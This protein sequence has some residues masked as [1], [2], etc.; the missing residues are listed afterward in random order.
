[1]KNKISIAAAVILTALSLRAAQAAED[2]E[3]WEVTSQMDMP[4][5]PSG[6]KMP[7]GMMGAMGGR[8]SQVCRGADP[9]EAVSKDK[10]MHDCK[11]TDFKEAGTTVSM[12]VACKDD[13][14]A[15]MEFVYNKKR[16]EYKGT[17]KMKDRKHGEMT[18]TTSGRKIGPCDATK[19]RAENAAKVEKIKSQAA[20]AQ[21]QYEEMKK[22]S[23]S[24]QIKTCAKA[25]DTMNPEGL[26]FYGSCRRKKDASCKSILDAYE[27]QQPKAA[28]ACASKTDEFCQRYQTQ[29]GF[30]KVSRDRSRLDAAAQMCGVPADDLRAK[31]CKGA[32]KSESFEF[33]GANCPAQ[34]KPLAKTHC[35]GRSFTVKEGDPRRVEKKW[36]KFCVA[37][38]GTSAAGDDSEQAVETAPSSKDVKDEAKSEAKAE[39]K[40]AAKDAAVNVIKGL[41][42][43]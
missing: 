28:A 17:M 36:F 24:D 8:T 25:V 33:V 32:L 21:T 9:R 16:T 18:M 29:D 13:R 10:E 19:A 26:G 22:K 5:M 43:R 27:K 35:A 39:T 38:A 42:G 23:E 1:M 3:L 15:K 37:V 12:T 11:I 31:L 34:A 20:S 40:K 7:A 41:F 14:S 6:R 4:A 2:G 30:L